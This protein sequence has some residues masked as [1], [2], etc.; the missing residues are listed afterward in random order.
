[1]AAAALNQLRSIFPANTTDKVVI[2]ESAD[3]YQAAVTY[4]WSQTCWTSAAAYVYL[5]TV[6]E[7]TKALAIVQETGTKFAVRTTGHNPNAG[8]SS[9]GE[10][11]VVLDIRQLRSKELFRDQGIARV[12]SG[13]TWGEVYSWLEERGLSAIGGRDPQVG[14]GG[15]LLGGGM[16]ALPNLYG[17]GADGVKNFEVLLAD[18]NLINAN[19]DENSDLYRALK[20]GGS[21]FGIVTRFDLETHPLINVQYTINLYNPE[22]HVAIN[23]ATFKVQQT[24]EEDPKIGLFTNFNNGFVAVGLLYGDHPAESETRETFRPFHDLKSLVTTVVPSTNGTLST[25]AQAMG[26][27][28]TS[29]KRSICTLTTQNSPELYEEVYKAW[30]EVCKTLPTN[31]VLHYTIQPFGKAAVQAG[32]DRGKN[33]MGHESIPQ[34]WWVFTCEWPKDGDDTAAQS[35]VDTM[36][37]KVQYLAKERGLLLE[38]KCMSFATASQKVLG[39]YGAENIK[40]MQQVAAKY[41]P[42]EVFQK[43]QNGGFLL[44]DNV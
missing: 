1:M 22:D 21:N 16:G 11:A 43:L 29:L 24:M 8:F 26:H 44:R 14:L 40:R 6:Q 28:Q 4:P 36:S 33:I 35:A 5:S 27:A 13:N 9:A 7:L 25:L 31:T 15:F 41:D 20:G 10:A 38:F 34:C 18:G 30:V 12:G 2:N 23:Q 3:K 32:K 37:E 42:E 19:K 17:L 39:S